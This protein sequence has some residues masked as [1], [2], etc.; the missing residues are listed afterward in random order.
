MRKIMKETYH[1]G[2]ISASTT[3]Q[4]FTRILEPQPA[5]ISEIHVYGGS[6][7]DFDVEIY[8]E[9]GYDRINLIAELLSTN[10]EDHVIL[11]PPVLISNSE[12]R[13]IFF[14]VDNNDASNPLDLKVKLVYEPVGE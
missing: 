5:R 11:D 1:F 10:V 6:S 14:K 4:R 12:K 8:D 7:T 2:R 13:Y 3:N 9:E